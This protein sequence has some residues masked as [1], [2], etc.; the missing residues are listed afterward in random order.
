MATQEIPEDKNG[1]FGTKKQ[2]LGQKKE[3]WD[4]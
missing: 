3:I 4:E 1:V 2:K